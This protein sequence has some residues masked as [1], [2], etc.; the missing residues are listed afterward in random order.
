M[1]CTNVVWNHK[2]KSASLT[3]CYLIIASAPNIQGVEEITGSLFTTFSYLKSNSYKSRRQMQ[4]VNDAL[5]SNQIPE[6]I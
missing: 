2:K 5:Y 4:S 3:D 6:Q 1:K